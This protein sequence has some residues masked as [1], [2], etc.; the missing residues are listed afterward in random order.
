MG[1]D[2]LKIPLNQRWERMQLSHA[3]CLYYAL[4]LTANVDGEI[5]WSSQSS[6]VGWED[7]KRRWELRG[8]RLLKNDFA[9]LWKASISPLFLCIQMKTFL[10]S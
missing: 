9:E 1:E 5:N 6:F 3:D 8:P 2:G 10:F 7:R 4:T